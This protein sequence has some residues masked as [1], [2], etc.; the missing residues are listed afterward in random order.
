MAR[1]WLRST[2]VDAY[3]KGGEKGITVELG[4]K[5]AE[6]TDALRAQLR[7]ALFNDAPNQL[8]AKRKR[9]LKRSLCQIAET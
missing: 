9:I 8:P 7:V 5:A 6:W 3:L 2:I 1:L 4:G